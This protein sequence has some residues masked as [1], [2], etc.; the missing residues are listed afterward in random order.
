MQTSLV[1]DRGVTELRLMPDAGA[2]HGPHRSGGPREP[3][4]RRRHRL[5]IGALCRRHSEHQAAFE[6]HHLALLLRPQQLPPLARR[7][8]EQD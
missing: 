6:V 2:R 8:A 1:A 3:P 7:A 4:G 5:A